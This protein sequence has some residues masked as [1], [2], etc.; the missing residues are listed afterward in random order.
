MFSV[1]PRNFLG[2]L[3]PTFDT[4]FPPLNETDAEWKSMGEGSR[5]SQ[6]RTVFHFNSERN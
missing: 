5:E 6:E 1:K 2:D 4:A 3:S